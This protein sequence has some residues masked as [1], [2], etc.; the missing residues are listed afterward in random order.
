VE[1]ESGESYLRSLEVGRRIAIDVPCA[2]AGPGSWEADH[3]RG[4]VNGTVGWGDEFLADYK[5]PLS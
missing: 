1:P 3:V 2:I 4:L 5:E